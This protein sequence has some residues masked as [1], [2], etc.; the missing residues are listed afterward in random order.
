MTIIYD[1]HIDAN[2]TLEELDRLVNDTKN[3]CEDEMGGV[4][5]EAEKTLEECHESGERMCLGFEFETQEAVD[6]MEKEVREWGDENPVSLG[7]VFGE[8]K[9]V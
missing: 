2:R 5:I 7:G 3:W 6:R 4:F 9:K 8:N 1:L